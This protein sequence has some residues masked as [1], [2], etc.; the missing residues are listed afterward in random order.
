MP[1][2]NVQNPETGQWRAF[3]SIVDDFVTEW[4]DEE[5]YEKWRREQYGINCGPVREANL[6][7]LEDALQAKRI[8]EEMEAE[9]DG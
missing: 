8:R 3:S 1:R 4:M 6:M 9:W 7:S 2:Y 5:T